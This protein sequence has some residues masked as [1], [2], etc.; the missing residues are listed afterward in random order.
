MGRHD[1]DSLS[2]VFG[3]LFA[4]IGIALMAGITIP[5]GLV[6][7]WLG[8]SVAIGLGILILIAARPRREPAPSD[9]VPSEEATGI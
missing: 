4:G 3:L 1:F 2:F 8:P 9:D 7:P 6:V 5:N